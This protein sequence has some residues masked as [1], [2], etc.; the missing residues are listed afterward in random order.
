MFDPKV[1]QSRRNSLRSKFKNGILLFP[2]NMETAMNY[3]ANTY[4]FRQDSCFLYYFGLNQPDL[5]GIIDIDKGEDSIFGNDIDIEDII[6]MGNLPSIAERASLAGVTK[7]LPLANLAT[8]LQHP[9]NKKRPIHFLNPYRG[10][11][12]V[13]LQALL[14]KNPVQ[15]KENSSKELAIVIAQMRSIKED[16]EIVEIEKVVDVAGIM[17]TTAMRMAMPGIIERE[18]AGIIEGIALSKGA[19]VSFPIIATMHGETLHNHHH[20]NSLKQNDLLII[21]AGA[22]SELGYASDITRTS[23]V[24]G[25]FTPQQKEIY[26]L[27]LAANLAAIEMA[28]PGIFYKDV[29]L[30]AATVIAEGLKAIGL[31]KGNIQEA[32][33]Q[34]AH[35][36]FF[37]HGLG[38]MMGLDV[39]DMENI[40]ENYVGYDNT[41]ARSSQFGL[42]YLRLGKKLETGNVIT[43]EPGIYFIP[44]LID[45]WQAEKKFTEFI[46]YDALKAYRNFG[47][48]RLEDDLLITNT[49]CRVLGK[50][51]PKTV[52]EVEA[53][54]GK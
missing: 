32:V 17:H 51:I 45:L 35:A 36:L 24:G 27:V 50:P 30:K 25:T 14:D 29:H 20:G 28:K 53:I 15:L 6:W 23:P 31:M 26:E 3:K 12:I 1:Y 41:I 33:Q 9:D 11:T 52:K 7:T 38:H 43:D 40:G 34:G 10:E 19:G 42:A 8:F 49:G 48:I 54:V 2:G 5:F 37:P 16:R 44:A 46:N 47:G 4:H 13:Q 21:D 39:H 22:E 18:I